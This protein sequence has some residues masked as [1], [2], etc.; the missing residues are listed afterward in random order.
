M[1]TK[2]SE[3]PDKI[4]LNQKWLTAPYQNIY[5]NG[6]SRKSEAAELKEY[7]INDN[8][9]AYLEK[10]HLLKERGVLVLSSSNHYYYEPE[11]MNEIKTLVNVKPLN[12]VD[13]MK[14]FLN[15]IFTVIP[16]NS[17]LIGCFSDSRNQNWFLSDSNESTDIPDGQFDPEEH[18]ISSRNPFLNM[19]Y[20]FLD[21]RTNRYLTKKSVN[22]QLR[23][24]GW[25]V[26]DMSDIK[27]LTY[28]CAQKRLYD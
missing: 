24:S 19:V 5:P 15:S 27:G 22:L 25:K 28:F 10:L 6:K 12:H 2:T 23:S 11:D 13:Q 21:I 9:R 8:F 14:E 26:L 18:G 20:K 7:D 17:Y 3:I 4:S 16:Q 1:E